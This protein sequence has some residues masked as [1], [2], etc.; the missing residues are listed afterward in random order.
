MAIGIF[1]AGGIARCL[2]ETTVG[3]IGVGGGIAAVVIIVAATGIQ[4]IAGVAT[5][6]RW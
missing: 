5:C 1:N 2:A 6:L 4:L 3:I